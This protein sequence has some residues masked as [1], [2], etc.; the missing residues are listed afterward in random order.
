MR[1]DL[2]TTRQPPLAVL[3]KLTS[4]ANRRFESCRV[5]KQKKDASGAD[6]QELRAELNKKKFLAPLDSDNTRASIYYIKMKFIRY[7]KTSDTM[8]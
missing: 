1:P 4:F 3:N 6:Y 5:E 8:D 7:D 2:P